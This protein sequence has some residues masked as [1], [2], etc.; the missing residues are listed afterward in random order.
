MSDI[1]HILG[2]TGDPQ[3]PA[4]ERTAHEHAADASG[5]HEH[6]ADEHGETVGLPLLPPLDIAAARANLARG[7]GQQF[8]RSLDELAG[9]PEFDA[10]VDHEFP[11][12]PEKDPPS[13]GIARRDVLKLMAASAALSGLSA[14]TKLPT[15]KIVPYVKQP[16]EIIPGKARFYATSMP[17]PN[18]ALGLLVESNMGRPT[19]IEGNSEHPASLGATSAIAQASVL[20]LYDPDRSQVVVHEGRISDWAAFLNGI[21]NVRGDW[22]EKKGAG[23]RILTDATTSPTFGAQMRVFLGKFPQAKWHVHEPYGPYNAREGARL[24]FGKNVNAVYRVDQADVIV[25]LDSDFLCSGDG[26][27]RYSREFADR[28]RIES[29]Q[30]SMNRLYS[31]E[32]TPTNTG[33]MADHRLPL[34]ASQVEGFARALAAAVSGAESSAASGEASGVP[35][36]WLAALARDLQKHRGASLVIAGEAQPPTVHALAH[37][38]NESLGNVGRTLVYTDP[39]EVSPDVDGL[40]ELVKDID[41]GQVSTLFILGSNPVYSAPADFDFAAKY[42]KVPLRIHLGLY[43]DETAELSHWH[44][45]AAHF[46]ESWSDARAFDGTV[47]IVQPLIAPLY[48]GKSWHELIAVLAGDM[49]KSAHDIVRD[50]W[51]GQR[52]AKE[53]TKSFEDF[54]ETT[55]HDGVLAGSA[56]PAHAAAATVDAAKIPGAAAPAPVPFEIIF[57][58]DPSIGDGRDANNG[59]LQELPTPLTK[60]TWDNAVMVSAATALELDVTNGDVV[61]LTLGERQ[62]TGP[63]WIMPGHAN[64]SV[65]VH[66]GYGRR[67]AGHLGTGI[68]FDANA[69][70]TSSAPWIASGARI[71]KTGER[72]TMATTQ[73]HQAMKIAGREVER[74]STEAFKRDIMRVGTLGEFRKNP[75]FAADSSEAKNPDSLYPP[76]KYDG[77]AWGMSVDL[78]SCNGC[79]ACVIACQSENNIAVV[80]KEQ[81]AAGRHMQWIRVDNYFRGDLDNPESYYEPV[82]CQQCENAPCELVCPVGATTHSAEGLNEMTYNRCVGTRYCSNNCPYKVRRFNFKLYSDWTTPSLF[83]LRNPNVTVRSRG[84]MEKCT[85]CVQRIN[86]AKM[87]SEREDRS[88]RDGDIVTACEAACPSNAIVFGNINDPNSRVS[89]LKAQSRNFSLL[90]ELNTRPRTTYLARLRNPNPEIS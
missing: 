79:S 24:A 86:E 38:L 68:G 64:E 42:V 30:S 44:I 2:N 39:I 61:R 25:A 41:A 3:N 9:T 84:V 47:G 7:G 83:G 54:W 70:R 10:F 78:N 20:T 29:P 62:V 57:R 1:F 60:L 21:G 50:Y 66:L 67:R 87:A 71:E 81:V 28:R 73:H 32:S 14:C 15:E 16:E 18:G 63:I 11:N 8:W 53:T 6:A 48:D 51:K 40:G 26:S 56:L 4:N 37:A 77:Y 74:E 36:K 46:L 12:D 33:A 80:G 75:D 22:Q 85:Y 55:L 52:P 13:L 5:A 31:V 19:K 49:G 82:L 58:P 90:G 59:W 34:R 76:Y 23:L 69:L 27:V 72:Y 88:V 35:P 17:T 65:T 45:P 43:N 89:K